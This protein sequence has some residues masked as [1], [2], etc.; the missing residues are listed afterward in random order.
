MKTCLAFA[1]VAVLC[2]SSSAFSADTSKATATETQSDRPKLEIGTLRCELGEGTNFVVG[3]THK[4][5]CLFKSTNGKRVEAY[6]GT[7][8]SYGIDIGPVTSGTL[9][10]GVFAP[11]VDLK[12]GSL[13]GTY[14]GVSAGIALG[15]GVQANALI[16]GLNKSIALQPFSLQ[17]Q[18]GVNLTAGVTGLTLVQR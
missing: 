17:G 5:G 14:A 2:F 3:S 16:G 18:T 12:L 9:V 15:A 11:A 4:L 6:T 1:A 10:W 13:S 8:K 7:I